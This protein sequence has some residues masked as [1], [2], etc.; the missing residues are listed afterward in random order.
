MSPAMTLPIA[1]IIKHWRKNAEGKRD[2]LFKI[3]NSVKP[4]E[5]CQDNWPRGED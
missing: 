2:D 5:S 4:K 3:S 1:N